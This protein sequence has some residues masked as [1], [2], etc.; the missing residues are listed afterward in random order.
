MKRVFVTIFSVCMFLLCGC[1]FSP[2][3]HNGSND[4]ETLKGWSFQ[5]NPGTND[6]SLFFGLL[7]SN[8][9]Y[10]VDDRSAFD[11]IT[12]DFVY[13]PRNSTEKILHDTSERTS[14][15]VVKEIE[16]DYQKYV[17]LDSVYERFKQFCASK[18][19]FDPEVCFNWIVDDG[20]SK[21]GF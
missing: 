8:D 5:S 6:Y 2:S 18:S 12:T 13:L 4:I 9:K 15:L 19:G 16:R 7:N 10:I 1:S 14:S 21:W 3:M 20:L 17:L 11:R